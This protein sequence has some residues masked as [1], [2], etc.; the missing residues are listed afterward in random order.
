MQLDKKP[1]VKLKKTQQWFA[2]ILLMPIDEDSRM[3][4]VS[5]SGDYMEEE[6][7]DYI[8][9]SPTLRP[10][11]RIQLYNQQYWWR[12]LNTLH[13]ALPLVIRLMGYRE[14]N[15]NLG[16]PYLVDHPPCSW[17]LNDL[18]N[19]LPTWI[20]KNYHAHDKQLILNAAKLDISLNTAFFSKHFKTIPEPS[21]VEIQSILK[22]KV[23]LQSHVFL[24]DFPYHLLNFRLEIL[25]HD[26]DYW[27]R[28]DFPKLVQDRNYYFILYRNVQ[29][30]LKWEE[31]SPTAFHLLNLFSKGMSIEEACEWLEK[32]DEKIYADAASNLHVW[33]QKWIFQQWLVFDP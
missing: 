33:I 32:Q 6:A 19:E 22:R 15:Q 17:S 23:Y 16:K 29:N 27:R 25:Q 20:E 4:P 13:D 10:A 21:S 1:P 28:Q 14:F 2:S 31:I 3:C 5:P 30:N 11:Q 8:V 26:V 7:F 9:P 24:F 18:G 12:L